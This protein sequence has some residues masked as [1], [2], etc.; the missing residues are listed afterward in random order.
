[1][2]KI[3]TYRCDVCAMSLDGENGNVPKGWEH[4]TLVLQNPSA[5]APRSQEPTVPFAFFG[6]SETKPQVSIHVCCDC[7]II[8]KAGPNPNTLNHI[9]SRVARTEAF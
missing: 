6:P 2:S 8:S 1:M 3:L 4:W 9:K 5:K 7:R